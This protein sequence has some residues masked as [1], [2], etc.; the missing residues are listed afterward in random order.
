MCWI[1]YIAPNME[2]LLWASHGDGCREIIYSEERYRVLVAG[3]EASWGRWES[4][5]FRLGQLGGFSQQEGELMSP[6]DTM[7][8]TEEVRRLEN[9]IPLPP[10]YTKRWL[11]LEDGWMNVECSIL[12]VVLESPLYWTSFLES[13][14]PVLDNINIFSNQWPIFLKMY[15]DWD[16]YYKNQ[17]VIIFSRLFLLLILDLGT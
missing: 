8:I 1:L 12:Q 3:M 2:H 7:Y 16:P 11:Q 10:W 5:L 17:I 15:D 4:I 9:V 13:W 6:E 14:V